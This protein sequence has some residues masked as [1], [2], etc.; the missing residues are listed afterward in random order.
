MPANPGELGSG[1][2]QQQQ[3]Q[4]PKRESALL[5]VG[6]FIFQQAHQLREW[7]QLRGVPLRQLTAGLFHCS[8]L[9]TRGELYTLGDS[10]GQDGSNGNLLGRGSSHA[11][12]PSRVN[13]ESMGPIAE[14]NSTSYATMA[15][16][17]DGRVFSW[18]DCDG[19]ALCHDNVHCHEPHWV[20]SLRFQRV[21][22]GSLSYTNAAVATDEGRVFV[23]GGNAWEGGIAQNRRSNEAT[24]VKW[25][26]VPSCYRCSSVALAYRHGYLV[27]RKQP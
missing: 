25:S 3:Q 11:Q 27:F 20:S 8:A 14:V 15:I 10:T 26:G 22:H 16:T 6:A 1:E 2:Q 17:M 7:P 21:A 5:T 9:T 19:N 13:V 12:E 23:W 24:E 18:G 4:Q